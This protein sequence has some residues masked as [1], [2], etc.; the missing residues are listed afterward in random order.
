MRFIAIAIFWAATATCQPN[1]KD[2]NTS[3]IKWMSFEEAVLKGGKEPKKLFIDV[4]TDWCGWCKKMDK[5]T[6]QDAKIADEINK[7]FYPVKLDAERKDT[8]RFR[9]KIFV[10]KPEFKAHEL[11]I[12]LLNGQMGYPTYVFLDENFAMISPISGYQTV[13]QLLPTLRYFS[14]NIY[15][16]KQWDDYLKELSSVSK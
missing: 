3:V 2:D 4:Y 5:T 6:F 13:E 15:K 8:V 16:N 9:D 11:A 1:P 10:F 12:A 7:H 14:D